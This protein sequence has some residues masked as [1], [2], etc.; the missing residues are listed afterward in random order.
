MNNKSLLYGI[1]LLA[2]AFFYTL[3]NIYLETFL[4]AIL[5]SGIIILGCHCLA[6]GLFITDS[7]SSTYNI[8]IKN[9]KKEG[10]EE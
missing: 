3:F 2:L 9:E 7:H 6:Y 1:L 4:E 10:R 5:F 8:R